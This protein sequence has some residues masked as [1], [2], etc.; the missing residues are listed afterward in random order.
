MARKTKDVPV[1]HGVSESQGVKLIPSGATLLD[2]ACSDTL[3]GFCLTGTA[4]NIAG[5][6]NSGKTLLAIAS[7]AETFYRYGDHFEY[8]LYDTENAYSFDTAHLFG[9]AFAEALEVIAIPHDVEWCTEML[10]HK[11]VEAMR[12]KPQVAVIDSMD[13]LVPRA[14]IDMSEQVKSGKMG[15]SPDG[16]ANRYFFR[17]VAP[18]LGETSSALIYLSQA[19]DDI[20]SASFIKTKTRSG[21]KALGFYAHTEIWLSSAGQIQETLPGDKKVRVGHWVQARVERSKI[22]GKR[23]VVK[24]PVLSAYGI[25]NTQA[26][27]DWLV[28]EGVIKC[29]RKVYDLKGLGY[30]YQGKEPEWYIEDNNKHGE[31]AHA[32][33]RKWQENEDLLVEKTLGQ[34]RRRYA[35]SED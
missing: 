5:D 3:A 30:D 24:F 2:L 11:F 13:G 31:L 25:D 21:G 6:R 26:N 17:H 35:E 34:R 7:L 12:K 22:N 20:G 8:K 18:V 28:E 4:T 29:A 27:L 10:A 32:V 9:R 23:R 19:R 14:A 15:F 33:A 16:K 1:T